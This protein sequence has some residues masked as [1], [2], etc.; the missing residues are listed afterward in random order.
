M[1][2][3]PTAEEMETMY[4]PTAAE[5]KIRHRTKEFND[6]G[7]LGVVHFDWERTAKC[8]YPDHST[9]TFW[10]RGETLEECIQT[11]IGLIRLR[12]AFTHWKEN[13]A[14][15]SPAFSKKLFQANPYVHIGDLRNKSYYLDDSSEIVKCLKY[16]ST[17]S[18]D[19]SV[20]D[21]LIFDVF[22]ALRR[23]NI[24]SPYEKDGEQ[25]DLLGKYPLHIL[26]VLR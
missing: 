19:E 7:Y 17:F 26:H 11:K 8:K 18:G 4:I 10:N 2:N 6:G 3:Y 12:A 15:K 1:N 13:Q 21:D 9:Y 22:V 5:M 23:H 14:E 25:I 20:D 16:I 24:D